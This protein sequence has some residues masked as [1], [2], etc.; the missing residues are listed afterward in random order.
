M[1][2]PLTLLISGVLLASSPSNAAD[3][4]FYIG[5]GA[6]QTNTEVDDFLGTGFDFDENDTGFKLFGG[7][8][9][10]PWFSVEGIYYDGGSPE[11]KWVF[12]EEGEESE[13]I[14]LEVSSLVAAAVFALPV[15]K[16]FEVFL[17][18]G[19]AYWD[20]DVR[21]SYSSPT[22]SDSV[23]FDDTGTAFFIGAG[24]GWTSGNAGLRLEYEWFDVAP[25]Y[26]SDSEEFTDEL[27]ASSSFLSL[28]VIYNF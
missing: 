28:S 22:F 26:D 13:S 7:Y 20:S 12:G 18:P 17:K 10:F 14:N 15:G 4:G 27:D 16:Q 6:G 2:L 5:V 25:E 24:A 8:R 21:L 11:K 19:F 3:S 9:F 23:S 1:R